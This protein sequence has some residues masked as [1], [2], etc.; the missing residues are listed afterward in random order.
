MMIDSLADIDQ[1]ISAGLSDTERFAET[2]VSQYYAYIHRLALSI[3]HDQAD[4]DDACQETFIDAL[5]YIERYSP[6][7]NFK[8]WLSKIAVHKCWQVQR[9]RRFRNAFNLTRIKDA[10]RTEP[11]SPFEATLEREKNAQLWAAIDALDEK[12]RL[13]V[14]LYYVYEFK[15]REVAEI[16]DIPEGTACSRLHYA[17][18]KLGARLVGL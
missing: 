11:S 8:A 2:L 1:M 15:I 3:L 14:I 12:H 4:A 17:V 5:H 7:T 6:G 16:L 18:K 9:K 13:P 10:S